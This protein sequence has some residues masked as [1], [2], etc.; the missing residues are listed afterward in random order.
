MRLHDHRR[1]ARRGFTMIE[2]MVA[3]AIISILLTLTVGGAAKYIFKAKQSGTEALLQMLNNGIAAR[4]ESFWAKI[5]PDPL[6]RHQWLAGVPAAVTPAGQ[7]LAIGSNRARLLAKLEAMRGDFPQQFADFIAGKLVGGLYVNPAGGLANSADIG[8]LTDNSQAVPGRVRAAIERKYRELTAPLVPGNAVRTSPTVI[9]PHDPNTESAACLY[10]MLSVGSGEGLT[11]D[12]EALPPKYIKDTD[13]DGVPEIVDDWGQPLRFYRWP[14][15]FHYHNFFQNNA[16][17]VDAKN[18]LDP[19]GLLTTVG[20]AGGPLGAMFQANDPAAGTVLGGQT[21]RLGNFFRIRDPNS[22]GAGV[23]YDPA[24]PI[25]PLS[26][27]TWPII[28]SAGPG[29]VDQAAGEK[30]QAFGLHYPVPAPGPLA[31]SWPPATD[32]A[33]RCGRPIDSAAYS[34]TYTAAT[35]GAGEFADNLVTRAQRAGREQ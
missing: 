19:E 24:N 5:N 14:T 20:W 21:L 8:L 6:L 10:L 3:L 16:Y 15:D 25:A 23:P 4:T 32:L 22:G 9:A 11:F 13:N 28:V 12:L 35:P 29:S 26:I 7:S 18:A 31:V 17:G 33:A 34:T 1:P 27:P 30:W 2:I